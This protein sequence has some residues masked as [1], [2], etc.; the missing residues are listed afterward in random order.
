M[1]DTGKSKKPD[2]KKNSTPA[3][4][5]VDEKTKKQAPKTANDY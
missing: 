5:P 3:L 2:A 4:N 1:P